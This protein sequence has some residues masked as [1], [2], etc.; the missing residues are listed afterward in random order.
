MAL[1]AEP[2]SSPAVLRDLRRVRPGDLAPLLAEEREAWMRKFSWDQA[3]ALELLERF[4]ADLSLDGFALFHHGRPAGYCYYV[5]D[6]PKALI[7][8]LYAGQDAGAEARAAS[9]I[10]AVLDTLRLLPLVTRIEAQLLMVENLSESAW[11][12]LGRPRWFPRLYMRAGL[13]QAGSLPAVTRAG[14]AMDRWSPA[15]L[16]PASFLLPAAYANH[17]DAD[18]N[19]QYRSQ[20]GARRFLHNVTHFPGCGV[21]LPDASFI[22]AGRA[23]GRLCGMVL[24][25]RI[26]D[27]SG[28]IAQLCVA[29]EFRGAGVGYALLRQAMVALAA[30]GF[31][32][33]SL[34]VTR[35]NRAAVDLYQRCGFE[36]VHEFPALVWEWGNA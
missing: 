25:S 23:D 18:I 27:V 15:A 21:F 4:V 13:A 2:F 29:P 6:P 36:S 33:V 7:G 10:A 35:S 1:T 31:R 11:T 19:E 12:R 26:S 28:H 14:F 22:A 34:S 9:L 5:L 16:D 17:V 24:A 30:A 8:G 20:P 32:E 3:A